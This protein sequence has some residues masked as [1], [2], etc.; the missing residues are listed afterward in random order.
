TTADFDVSFQFTSG[1]GTDPYQGV[2]G[3]PFSVTVRVRWAQVR[4]V[5]LGVINPTWITFTVNWQMLV[6]DPFTVNQTM[7]T[8]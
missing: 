1:S 8:F 3:Q 5:N 7:P 4:W 2:K 6:D